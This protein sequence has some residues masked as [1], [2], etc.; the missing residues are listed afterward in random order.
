MSDPDPDRPMERASLSKS[1][2]RQMLHGSVWLVGLRWAMRLT[3]VVST[4]VLA[5]LLA[6][7]DFGVVAIAMIVVGMFEV[8][9]WTGQELAIIRHD[10]PTAEHYNTAWT[11]SVLIGVVIAG[12]IFFAAPLFQKYFHEPAATR[13]MQWLALRP[14]LSGLEN[15]GTVDFQRS[16]RFD[17]VFAYN[18]YAKIT[19]F[20]VTLVAA[21]VLRNYWALVIGTIVGQSSRTFFS[22]VLHPYRPKLSVSEFADIWSFSLWSFCRSIGS[23]LILQVDL[24]AIGGVYGTT[25]MGRYTVAKDVASSA[26]EEINEP[27]SA[28]LFPV[29]AR[30]RN[31]PGELKALYLR[32]LGW[33]AYIAVS[34]GVGIC[35]IGSDLVA[36]LLG[37]KWNDISPLLGWLALTA[38]A[39]ALTNSAYTVLDIIGMP[40]K[41]ARLQWVR[42]AILAVLLFPL[43]LHGSALTIIAGARLA[44]T[45]L[46]LPTLLGAVGSHLGLTVLD[47][48]NALWRPMVSGC[49]MALLLL[50]MNS[51]LTEHGLPRLLLDIS[52]GGV[53]FLGS[54]FLLW[55]CCACPSS[56]E[57]D[58]LNLYRYARLRFSTEA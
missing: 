16:L 48:A 8:L 56:P 33:A 18:F 54:N 26:V 9:S 4:L 10:R 7:R 53:V 52:V 47:Y 22:Y 6:P 23:Y 21:A 13:V 19:S 17:R 1:S 40:E 15:V 5:R 42:V 44:A 51:G 45:V 27:V 34:A 55:F 57:R 14:L 58:L 25:A 39:A 32:T 41:G 38:G 37:S 43:A 24:I 28:V 11:I 49:V 2:G 31:D 46:F 30:Y 36:V 3:G 29:M 12:G 20:V 35:V 50:W